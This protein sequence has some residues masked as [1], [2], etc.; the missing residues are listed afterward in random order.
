MLRRPSV[1][2]ESV[3]SLTEVQS[4]VRVYYSPAYTS[5]GFEFDTTRKAAW[6]ADSLS[7]SPIAGVELVEPL[8][9]TPEQV[10]SVHDPGYVR[11]VKTGRPR[12]LA[13]SNGFDWDR[14]LWLAALACNGGVVT[15]AVSALETGVAGSLSSGLHHAR[16]GSGSA[17]CTFNGLALAARAALEVGAGAVL[18]LDLD[19]HCG[20][21]TAS[22][23]EDE[24]AVW[25][26]DV[27]VRD[28]DSY[29]GSDRVSLDIVRDASEYLPTIRRRLDELDRQG[30]PFGLCLYYA[31]MDPHEGCPTG[32]TAGITEEVLA[33]REQLAFEWCRSRRLPVTFALAGGYVGPRLDKQRL[34]SLHRLT[35]SA[36]VAAER[37]KCS[38]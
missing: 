30:V 24:P 17:F 6:V 22:L 37:T 31:G 16:S 5:A 33:A 12:G 19:A 7:A 25:Q 15:A 8:P 27:A 35:I 4:A 34:V 10:S 28:F 13:E 29:T 21:G 38:T 9:L 11:A 20:G 2:L 3:S 32:G 1:W 36:A 26:L 23:I 14:G 18:I